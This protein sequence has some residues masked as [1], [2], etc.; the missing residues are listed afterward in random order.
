MSARTVVRGCA[1]TLGVALLLVATLYAL[2][3]PILGGMAE[4][5]I[6][7]EP[8]RRSDYL[9]LLNGDEHT[10]PFHAARL[11]HRGLAPRI[12]VAQAE[13]VP[14]HDLWFFPT[15][16][17]LA[18][19]VLRHEGVP[20][21]A[22]TVIPFPGGIGSTREEAEALRAYLAEHPARR[23]TV[24]TTTY[25]TRRARWTF[26]REMRGSGVEVRVSAAPEPRF[27]TSNWWRSEIGLLLHFQEY[28]K[29]LHTLLA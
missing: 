13:T 20:D 8:L 22:V 17:R 1:L 16:T 24:V 14:A 4:V 11:Y 2:R 15:A 7:D 3:R 27:Q 21:S 25:H 5:L 12:L 9:L 10:R 6:V 26:R 19:S 18:L 23:V 28:L 29:W